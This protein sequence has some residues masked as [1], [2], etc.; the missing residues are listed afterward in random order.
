VSGLWPERSSTSPPSNRAR[1]CRCRLT[2]TH[3][4]SLQRG[5]VWYLLSTTQPDAAARAVPLLTATINASGNDYACA[6]ALNL[7]GSHARTGDI[8]AAVSVGRHALEEISR[9]SSRRAYQR[10]RLLDL[11]RGAPDCGRGR[12]AI[13]PRR[14]TK[15][16]PPESSRWAPGSP[17]TLAPTGHPQPVREA[18]TV[19]TLWPYLPSP[20][21]PGLRTSPVR[22][23]NCTILTP[24]RRQPAELNR[25]HDSLINDD[26]SVVWR[27]VAEQRQ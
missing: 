1:R 23:G 19:A 22:C 15:R 14:P 25:R 3:P 26:R 20:R 16:G 17:S 12:A 18:G 13:P 2:S 5:H 8:D 6:R 27:S 24:Y 11:P 21:I 10:L 4:N 7:A 9:I